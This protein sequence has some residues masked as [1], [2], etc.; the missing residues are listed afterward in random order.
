L[1]KPQIAEVI[2]MRSRRTIADSNTQRERALR[3]LGWEPESDVGAYVAT[4][5][6]L[7]KWATEKKAESPSSQVF[8]SIG[9]AISARARKS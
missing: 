8:S 9:D 3:E 7:V 1:K 5:G 4:T 2:Y 6:Q